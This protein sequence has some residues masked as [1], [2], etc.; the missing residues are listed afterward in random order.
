MKIFYVFHYLFPAA[1]WKYV[2]AMEAGFMRPEG[3][4]VYQVAGRCYFKKTIEKDEEWKG[5]RS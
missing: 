4:V 3:V 2:T 1:E 5:K